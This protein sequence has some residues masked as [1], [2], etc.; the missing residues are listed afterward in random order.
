LIAKTAYRFAQER[1]FA[2]GDE[3]NDWLAAEK[4][5]DFRLIGEGRVFCGRMHASESA[6]TFGADILRSGCTMNYLAHLSQSD[7]SVPHGARRGDSRRLVFSGGRRA[8][9]V[10]PKRSPATQGAFI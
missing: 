6:Y 5:V 3:L 2:P 1:Q 4:L 9:C 8:C 7:F 10:C